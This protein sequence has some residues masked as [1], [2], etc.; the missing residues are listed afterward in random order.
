MSRLVEIIDGAAAGTVPLTTVLRQVKVLAMRMEAPELGS[1]VERE[2]NGYKADDPVPDYRGPLTLPVIGTWT[3]M[4]GSQ[5]SGQPVSRAGVPE[6]FLSTWFTLTLRQPVSELEALSQ[7]EKDP[8]VMWDPYAITRY[9][10]LVE[11]GKG[12]AGFQ[13]MSLV[14]AQIVV[15]TPAL[16]G[17]LDGVRNRVLDLALALEGIAPD[18][19]EPSGPTVADHRV[20]GVAQQFFITINGDGAN[21]AIGD[22]ARLKSKVTKGDTAGLLAAA[23]AL[24]LSAEDAEAFRS[25]LEA[26]GRS[27]G[28]RTTR[29]VSRVR[30]GAIALGGNITANLAASGLLELGAQFLG[31]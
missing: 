14:Q 23:R 22:Y 26:D 21:F 30:S 24:G 12:G 18:V 28:E 13:M 10:K 5:I 1:W 31:A 8:G 2:L 29:F 17:I 11:E 19:G 20:Q 7:S 16:I 4:F 3:G 27:D 25:A 6:A 9:N 15:P